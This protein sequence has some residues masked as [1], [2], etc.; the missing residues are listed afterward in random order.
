M[1]EQYDHNPSIDI[2]RAQLEKC[3][4]KTAPPPDRL[5]QFFRY[6]HLPV[7]LQEI[8]KPFCELTAL[9]PP[10]STLTNAPTGLRSGSAISA[11]HSGDNERI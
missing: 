9:R 2:L 3:A 8:S 6:S 10:I 11:A 4:E 5:L 1:P 7:E